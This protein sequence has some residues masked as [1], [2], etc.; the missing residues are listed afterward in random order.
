MLVIG[1]RER[2]EREY[3]D[4]FTGSGLRV[5]ATVPAGT[6]TVMEAVRA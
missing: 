1:G 3:R 4:L 6:H 2:G 5:S